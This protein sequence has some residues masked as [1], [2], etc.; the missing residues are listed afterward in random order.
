ML[1]P[2]SA[3]WLWHTM[4]AERDPKETDHVALARSLCDAG[5]LR[6]GEFTLKNGEVSPVYV[7]LR[8]AYAMPEVLV[9][10]ALAMGRVMEPIGAEWLAGPEL[11]GVPLA[12]ALSLLLKRPFC[13][14]RGEYEKHGMRQ[15]VD[16]APPRNAHAVIVDDVCTDG[17]TKIAA[18]QRL[19]TT[20]ARL[21]HAVVFVDRESGG[22]ARLQDHNIRLHACY[23]LREL[24]VNAHCAQRI[25]D[26][27]CQSVMDY[28]GRGFDAT[29]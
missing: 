11:S 8:A 13:C 16:P 1:L 12:T 21:T 6:F 18:A 15:I 29:R 14:V 2:Y 19:R 24:V 22:R 17:Q 26:S 10:I 25:S 3:F 9:E 28:L 5:C 20:G 23:T 4:D 27:A 7:N